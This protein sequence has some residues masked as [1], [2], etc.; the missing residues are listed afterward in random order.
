MTNEHLNYRFPVPRYIQLCTYLLSLTK[1]YYKYFE[2][3]KHRSILILYTFHKLY[4]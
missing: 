4:G 2:I 3:T 1:K